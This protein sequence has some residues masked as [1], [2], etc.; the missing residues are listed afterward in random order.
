MPLNFS[1][2]VFNSLNIVNYCLFVFNLLKIKFL[3]PDRML[4]TRPRKCQLEWNHQLSFL[5]LAFCLAE[6]PRTELDF[7]FS[8]DRYLD[9]KPKLCLLVDGLVWVFFLKAKFWKLTFKS[10]AMLLLRNLFPLYSCE[11]F[12]L[13]ASNFL[14]S[15]SLSFSFTNY[16]WFC[17]FI[18]VAFNSKLS[19][20]SFNFHPKL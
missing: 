4:N 19:M 2:N 13:P 18:K 3:K 11:C 12:L 9:H 7:L 16:G 5:Q 6:Q 20:F 8:K 14:H 15:P 10:F 1:S 17:Q